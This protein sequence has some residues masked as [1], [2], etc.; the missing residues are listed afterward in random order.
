MGG[1]KY[2]SLLQTSFVLIAV[3]TSNVSRVT[4]AVD[5]SGNEKGGTE[6]SKSTHGREPED[7]AKNVE[8]ENGPVVIELR[9]GA[10]A[11]RENVV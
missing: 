5:G 10:H 3:T 11:G 4:T 8:G 7:D 1:N 2:L 9:E 6:G